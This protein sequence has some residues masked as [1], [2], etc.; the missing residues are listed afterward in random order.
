MKPGDTIF[1]KDGPSII[2]RGRIAGPYALDETLSI[3]DEHD[4]PWPHH[5]PVDWDTSFAPL[6]ISVGR[7]QPIAVEKLEK[8]D[9]ER[10]EGASRRR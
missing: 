5:V 6:L 7:Q 4:I 2:C 8:A 3:V 10:L 9:V 1:V